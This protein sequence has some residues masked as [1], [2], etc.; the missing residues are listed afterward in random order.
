MGVVN[1]TQ[2]WSR[3]GASVAGN[4]ED[5]QYREF[6]RTTGFQVLIDNPE[7][8]DINEIENAVGIPQ[9]QDLYPFSDFVRCTNKV[10][11]RHSPIFYQVDCEYTGD[12]TLT[13]NRP[14]IT[15]GSVTSSEPVDV[16]W[17]GRAIV[18]VNGEPVAGISRDVSD[19][20]IT[21]TRNFLSVNDD[22]VLDYLEATNSDNWRDST[23]LK[24]NY[25]PGR[26]RLISYNAVEVFKNESATVGYWKV[27]A[28]IQCRRGYRVT[29]DK[30]WRA[31]YRNEGLMV[32]GEGVFTG[33][34]GRAYKAG[35]PTTTPVLLNAAGKE[36]TN[37]DNAIYL[38]AQVYGSLP[39]NALGLL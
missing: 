24:V 14:I 6:K 9:I 19:T 10:V 12:N 18:N 39:Y 15:K 30:A 37:A 23:G 3:D 38:T 1:V 31:R 11:I 2:M 32:K 25:S 13:L 17:F 21:I 22:L 20:Q 36:E 35:E 8:V 4:K 16:D 33:K 5:Q 29:P 26:C 27:T 28:T 34:L 7:T